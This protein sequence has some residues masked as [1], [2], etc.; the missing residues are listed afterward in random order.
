MSTCK[1]PKNLDLRRPTV[2]TDLIKELRV[3]TEKIIL[4]ILSK[5]EYNIH[6][7]LRN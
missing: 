7:K 3:S 1:A 2:E 5:I 6:I 4:D